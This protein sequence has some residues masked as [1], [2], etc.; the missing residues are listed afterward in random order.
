MIEEEFT[1][2]LIKPSEEGLEVDLDE[3]AILK[4]DKSALAS[5]YSTLLQSGVL[6]IDE[7]R[8]ELGYSQIGLDKHIIPYTDIT[9]NEVKKNGD[10]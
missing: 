10:K 9:Q 5:Y 3:T 7:V 4:A 6:C 2:K 1:R 8:S